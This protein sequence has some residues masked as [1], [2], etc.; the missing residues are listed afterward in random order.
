MVV[1]SFQ[2]REGA[3]RSS[4]HIESNYQ[5]LH[6]TQ[7]STTAAPHM[8]QDVTGAVT[9]SLLSLLSIRYCLPFIILRLISSRPGMPIVATSSCG[10]YFEHR[11][12][13]ARYDEPAVTCTQTLIL[14]PSYCFSR[15]TR[16]SVFPLRAEWTS[17]LH[18]NRE[19]PWEWRSYFL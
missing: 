7:F 11:G 15:L 10:A 17:K 9:E 5:N 2:A 19:L 8:N 13:A 12:N 14:K 3:Q 16:P 1:R 4:A 18:R 6:S